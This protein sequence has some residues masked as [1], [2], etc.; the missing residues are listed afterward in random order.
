LRDEVASGREMVHPLVMRFHDNDITVPVATHAFRLS[1]IGQ[2]QLTG[3]NKSA[4]R[5]EFL[6]TT[7]HIHHVEI[8]LFVHG[9]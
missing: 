4:I 2:R 3:Q 1:Q 5:G 6:Q 7:R 8:V 9:H